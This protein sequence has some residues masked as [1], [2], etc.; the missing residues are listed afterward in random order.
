MNGLFI[1]YKNFGSKLFR[2]VTV[3]VFGRRTNGQTDRKA[4]ARPC[5]AFL[6][7]R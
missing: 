1:W 6:V 2:F 4:T 7:A 3:H 5:V